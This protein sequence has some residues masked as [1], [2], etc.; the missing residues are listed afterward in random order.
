MTNMNEMTPEDLALL[1]ARLE[2]QKGKKA[3]TDSVS[4]YMPD[5]PKGFNELPQEQQDLVAAALVKKTT[6][7]NQRNNVA[8]IAAMERKEKNRIMNLQWAEQTTAAEIDERSAKPEIPSVETAASYGLKQGDYQHFL[9]SAGLVALELPFE[10][11]VDNTDVLERAALE[12]LPAFLNEYED[13]YPFSPRTLVNAWV[14]AMTSDAS[15]SGFTAVGVSE[16]REV[17][18]MIAKAGE[19][20]NPRT[21]MKHAVQIRLDVMT[22]KRKAIPLNNPGHVLT[23]ART[24]A[25]EGA[26]EPTNWVE[27]AG[28]PN[29]F[30]AS[31][32]DDTALEFINKIV[33]YRWLTEHRDGLIPSSATLLAENLLRIAIFTVNEGKPLDFRTLFG[34]AYRFPIEYL[35]VVRPSN[36]STQESE[37]HPL[38]Y[39]PMED[40]E[41]T[42]ES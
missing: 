28:Y 13:R 2:E 33:H 17:V 41:P 31:A 4:I 7:L 12:I 11:D 8:R 15:K 34:F 23:F 27:R 6:V 10:V 40:F 35:G 25:D 14:R 16:L 5:I 36:A 18:L 3:A 26:F 32:I 42:P 30:P 1:T 9:R 21:M 39:D 24:L 38:A 20:F 22:G 37:R 19:Q 29:A